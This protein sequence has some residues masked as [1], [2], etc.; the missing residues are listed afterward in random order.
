M[1]LDFWDCHTNT[2]LCEVNKIH[3]ECWG[4]KIGWI[5]CVEFIPIEFCLKNIHNEDFGL[6]YFEKK[7]NLRPFSAKGYGSVKPPMH[8]RVNDISHIGQASL[9]FRFKAGVCGYEPVGRGRFAKRIPLCQADDLPRLWLGPIFK[10]S[11]ELQIRLFL[12]DPGIYII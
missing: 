1:F 4:I 9:L 11:A 6:N 10:V 2:L 7:L 12:T 3:I 5:R 8:E